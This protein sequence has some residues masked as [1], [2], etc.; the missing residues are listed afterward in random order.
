MS[1]FFSA[2]IIELLKTR[3]PFPE[4]LSMQNHVYIVNPP[5]SLSNSM[6]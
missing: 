6:A 4:Q 3:L 1:I 2:L 5:D